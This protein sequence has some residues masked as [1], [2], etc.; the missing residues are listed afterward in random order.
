MRGSP[1]RRA[2]RWH[3]EPTALFGGIAM[4]VAFT[5]GLIAFV[6]PSRPLTGLLILTTIMF[7]TG[8][9]R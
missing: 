6:P 1:C 9:G 8:T 3:R 5:A 2:D 4:Y 7:V